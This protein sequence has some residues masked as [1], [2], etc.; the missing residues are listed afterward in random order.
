MYFFIRFIKLVQRV[1]VE[2][3]QKIV[4]VVSLLDHVR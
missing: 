3:V 2:T 1:L 4:Y